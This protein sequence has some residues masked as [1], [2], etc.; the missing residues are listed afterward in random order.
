M[1]FRAVDCL[2]AGSVS[3]VRQWTLRDCDGRRTV[4]AGGVTVYAAGGSAAEVGGMMSRNDVQECIVGMMS[5]NVL[6]A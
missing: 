2:P 6:G 4:H 1:S 5:R 3:G